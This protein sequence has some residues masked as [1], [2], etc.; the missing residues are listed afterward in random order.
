MTGRP[1]HAHQSETECKSGSV[2]GSESEDKKEGEGA[3]QNECCSA[4]LKGRV[5]ERGGF[6]TEYA[7]R[8]IGCSASKS[9]YIFSN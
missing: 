1:T 2:T 3:S 5:Q 7:L 8:K 6:E 9:E 4:R